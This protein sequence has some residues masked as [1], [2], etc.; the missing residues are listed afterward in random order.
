MHIKADQDIIPL[1]FLHLSALHIYQHYEHLAQNV[2]KHK[3]KQQ[4]EMVAKPKIGCPQIAA[5]IPSNNWL[6]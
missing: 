5:N 6:K 1:N 3:A 2:Y 4:A